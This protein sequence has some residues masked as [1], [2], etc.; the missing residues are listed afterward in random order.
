MAHLTPCTRV[1]D[2]WG[3]RVPLQCLWLYPAY[4]MGFVVNCIWYQEI[5]KHA[6]ATMPA[7]S[8]ASA[9]PHAITPRYHLNY[10]FKTQAFS[11]Y[12]Q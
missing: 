5:A 1:A 4:V 2:L 11:H 7:E 10:N 9:Q 6:H 3:M 12:I 8:A